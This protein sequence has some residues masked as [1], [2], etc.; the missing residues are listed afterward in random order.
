MVHGLTAR[1]KPREQKLGGLWSHRNLCFTI[2]FLCGVVSLHEVGR[3]TLQ[4]IISKTKNG[5]KRKEKKKERKGM[6]AEQP[7]KLPMVSQSP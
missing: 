6:E 1:I 4:M 7:H 2:S 5:K 3:G